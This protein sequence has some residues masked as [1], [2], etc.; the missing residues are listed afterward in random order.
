M[1]GDKSVNR[2]LNP[3]AFAQTAPGTLG[4]YVRNSIKGPAFWTIDAALSRQV[5]VGGAR[6]MEFRLETFN[7]LNTFNMGNPVTNFNAGNFGRIIAMAGAP[8][9]M[10]F[11]VKYGF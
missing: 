8:R 4:S 9:I 2:Y 6:S 7:L 10:Q 1:Y 5:S 11:G 3:A